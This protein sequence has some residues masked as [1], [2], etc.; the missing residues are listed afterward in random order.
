MAYKEVH[1]QSE[2][3]ERV[4]RGAKALTDAVRIALGPAE[5]VFHRSHPSPQTDKGAVVAVRRFLEI[6]GV[7]P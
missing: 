4:L 5:A 6:A 3:R 7:K 1:F 2:V